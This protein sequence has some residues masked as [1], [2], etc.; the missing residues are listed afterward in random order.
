MCRGITTYAFEKLG[1]ALV[2]GLLQI[3]GHTWGGYAADQDA[4]QLRHADVLR[5]R[6]MT[7]GQRIPG[8][9]AP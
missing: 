8:L 4:H 2:A 5:M 6:A 7:E 3:G 1:P 9:A